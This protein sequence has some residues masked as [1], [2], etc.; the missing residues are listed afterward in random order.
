M[1]IENNCNI[2]N[3]INLDNYNYYYNSYYSYYYNYYKN[4]KNFMTISNNKENKKTLTKKRKR[5]GNDNNIQHITNKKVKVDNKEV[6][7]YQSN[8]NSNY[9][10]NELQN[11]VLDLEDY[12]YNN[13]DMSYNK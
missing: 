10:L 3:Y 8:N 4:N 1:S 12:L 6:T 13:D 5:Q 2:N 9:E 7:D 11:M